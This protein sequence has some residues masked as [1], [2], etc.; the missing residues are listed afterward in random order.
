MFEVADLS[1]VWVWVP[2][3]G[4][5]LA[6]VAAD[7]PVAMKAANQGPIL[8]G[9]PAQVPPSLAGLALFYTVDAQNHGLFPGQRMD[10][11]L[12]EAANSRH[13]LPYSAVVYDSRGAS[14]VYTSN[15]SNVFERKP[16]TVELVEGTLA[17]I[18]DGPATGT[19]V[20]SIG[21]AELYAAEVGV[22]TRA[23]PSEAL[24]R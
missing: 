13:V 22:G 9:Q 23:S 4:M 14:W 17:V 10:V 18:A 15:K 6:R 5:D 8:T 1:R 12:G 11:E 2:L 3:S 24:Q 7:R 16:L 21:A 20:V 19:Y